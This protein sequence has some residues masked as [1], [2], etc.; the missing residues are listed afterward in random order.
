MDYIIKRQDT[1]KILKGKSWLLLYGRRK[2]G[3]TFL[4]R[5]LCKFKE[6]YT[7]KQDLSVISKNKN[8]SL[9]EMI[10]EVKDLLLKNKTVVIDEFQRLDMGILEEISLLHPKG[11]LILS[12]S[13]LRIIKKIFEVQS[14]VLGFFTPLK[15]EFIKPS[16]MLFNLKKKDFNEKILEL[17]SFLKEPWLIPIY[18]NEDILEFVYNLVIQSK[19]IITALVGEI[20]NEEERELSQKYLVLLHLIGSGVWNTKELTSIMY[21]R[22]LI[23]SPS[24]THIIQYL[25]NLEEME[26][27][28]SIK[29]NKSK[30]NYYRL[31]S[32]LM[33][34][35]Y[36][37][38]SRYNISDRK[39]SLDEVKPTL[40]KLINF[41]I[42]NFVADLFAEI[43]Q[44]RKEY[45][46]SS[47]KE[48]DFIITS[49]NKIKIIGEVKWKK[50]DKRDIEKFVINSENFNA[51]KILICKSSDIKNYKG[52][53]II[54]SKNLILQL[55]KR[56][57]N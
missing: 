42:Q 8:L 33:N 38:D 54:D 43:Y 36:Y 24:Q 39:I 30:G 16:D 19:Q 4:L 29:L 22:N 26:L 32:P 27:V 48:I 2:I 14:P 37:L 31:F 15:I 6:I 20:F 11:R 13:S 1:Q 25:K 34:I 50:V 35:Y 12:G 5:E 3:K 28:E 7:I 57:K 56:I 47:E 51:E 21:S 52:I 17:S 23:P 41:E 40:Q 45:F 18:N 10:K 53:E 46:V 9:S 55:N 44:G 49:R